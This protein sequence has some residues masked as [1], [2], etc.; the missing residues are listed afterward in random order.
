MKLVFQKH[1]IREIEAPNFFMHPAEMH[2]YIDFDVKRVYYL[3]KPTGPSGAHCHMEEKEFFVLVQGTCT[4]T[5]DY[6]KGIEDIPMKAND[7]L[8]I[9]NF[10]WH[11][12]GKFS[13]DAILLALSSTNYR[14]D[15]SDYQE[16]YVEYQKMIDGAEVTSDF[17]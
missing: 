17:D 6:G 15:R 16:D 14:P 2:E 7:A 12:F 3:T 1:S 9:G 8:Y 13:S 4:A 10:V 5:I 11:G